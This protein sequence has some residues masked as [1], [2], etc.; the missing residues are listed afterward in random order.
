MPV[1]CTTCHRV[2][3]R[4]GGRMC[5]GCHAEYVRGWRVRRRDR[6][7]LIRTLIDG[8]PRCRVAFQR[9]TASDVTEVVGG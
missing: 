2:P 6:E 1:F 4:K 3:R 7:A 5:L 9:L 8:C